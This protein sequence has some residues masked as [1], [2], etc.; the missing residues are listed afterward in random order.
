MVQL[1]DL[2][3]PPPPMIARCWPGLQPFRSTAIVVGTKADK[4]SRGRRR[5][6]EKQV[7]EVLQ[8]PPEIPLVSYS[9]PS[10]L[11]Q[12]VIGVVKGWVTPQRRRA[13]RGFIALDTGL[14]RG[15][16]GCNI[17]KIE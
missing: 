6:Q 5:Q 15:I 11:G 3:H 4:I 8:L 12:G 2:R 9:S 17:G 10:S 7:A 16:I 1:V 13:G 14:A